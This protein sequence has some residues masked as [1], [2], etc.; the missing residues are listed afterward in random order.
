[1]GRGIDLWSNICMMVSKS[2]AVP[3]WFLLW[4]CD[5]HMCNITTVA[6]LVT[7]RTA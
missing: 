5:S 4:P 3:Q 2:W 7:S 1:M 6:R